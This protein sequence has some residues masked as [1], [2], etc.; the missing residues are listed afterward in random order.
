MKYFKSVNLILIR[1]LSVIR[2]VNNIIRIPTENLKNNKVTA[3][4][5]FS[6]RPLIKI[7]PEPDNIL[8]VLVKSNKFSSSNND[9][10]YHML[11]RYYFSHQ[12]TLF[13]I[14]FPTC[15]DVQKPE[16]ESGI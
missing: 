13:L 6:V 16:Y 11:N 8:P 14:E 7:P 9:I 4:I 15:I 5:P 12:K 2:I 1:F 3:S 10:I